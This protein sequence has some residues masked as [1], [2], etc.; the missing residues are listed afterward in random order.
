RRH[1]HRIP[2][3]PAFPD[4]RPELARRGVVGK[5]NGPVPVGRIAG[6]HAPVVQEVVV[7]VLRERRTAVEVLP[8]ALEGTVVMVAQRS[9]RAA[10]LRQVTHLEERV[11]GVCGEASEAERHQ[12]RGDQYTCTSARSR[13]THC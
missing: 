9:Y 3:E 8:E 13:R 6:G 10:E 2:G 4:L 5:L 1:P 11:P 7:A 12:H